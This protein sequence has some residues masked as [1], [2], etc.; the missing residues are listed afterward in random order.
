MADFPNYVPN[1]GSPEAV[2][3]GCL[4]AVEDNNNGVG[5]VIDQYGNALFW[6]SYDCPV[7]GWFKHLKTTTEEKEI[8][9]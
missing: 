2:R 8:K 5:A 6:F 7:H 9:T 1:P 3:L 4:C